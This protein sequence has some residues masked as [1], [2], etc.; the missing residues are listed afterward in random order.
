MPDVNFVITIPNGTDNPT[1]ETFP[2]FKHF[3][4]QGGAA[5]WNIKNENGSNFQPLSNNQLRNQVLNVRIENKSSRPVEGNVDKSI[6]QE[7]I[8]NGTAIN[9][10]L[11]KRFGKN[12][13]AIKRLQQ[14]GLIPSHITY[15]SETLDK[16]G[17]PANIWT[18][19]SKK[20]IY[21]NDEF[22]KIME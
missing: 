22:I 12:S 8:N 20:K 7:T 14:A 18:V 6:T 9:T 11:E 1:V 10:L 2:S 4:M 17:H 19:L 13:P 21:V 5:R 16:G 3:L 15:T